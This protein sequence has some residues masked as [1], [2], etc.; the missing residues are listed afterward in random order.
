MLGTLTRTHAQRRLRHWKPPGS[1]EG[2]K[3]VVRM[4]RPRGTLILK[5]TIPGLVPVDTV[6]VIVNELTLVG[7]RCGRFEPAMRLLRT[8]K[9]AVNEM[10]SEVLPL[11][12]APGRSPG[13][14]R[15]ERLKVLFQSKQIPL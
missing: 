7:S 3:Q 8:G 5:S 1:P 9:V 11:S 6:R 15:R 12:A 13:P 4:T 2:L 14:R 10:I